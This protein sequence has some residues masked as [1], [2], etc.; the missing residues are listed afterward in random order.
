M[1]INSNGS[2]SG[3][4]ELQSSLWDFPMSQHHGRY[5]FAGRYNIPPNFISPLW[6]DLSLASDDPNPELY[7]NIRYGNGADSCEFIVEWDSLGVITPKGSGILND[8]SVFRVVL[9]K[10][11]QSIEYQ[12]DNIGIHGID[13]LG[14]IGMQQD[15]S[16]PSGT[17]P[18]YLF[19]NKNG[20][21]VETKIHNNFCIKFYAGAPLYVQPGWQLISPSVSRPGGINSTDVFG[22]K[23]CPFNYTP[24][25]G[26]YLLCDSILSP[27]SAF[28]LRFD[29]YGIA[30]IPGIPITDLT[31]N[32]N[33]GWNMI[34]GISKPISTS[35]IEKSIGLITSPFFK[36]E[37]TYNLSTTINPGVGYWVKANQAGTLYLQS[38]GSFEKSP[39][40]EY[41]GLHKFMFRNNAGLGQ[42]LYIGSDKT[43]KNSRLTIHELPPPAPYFN[44]RFK[45][46]GG[47]IATYPDKVETGA[48]NDYPISFYSESY[49]ITVEWELKNTGDIVSLIVDG[50][51]IMLNQVGTTEIRNPI[52]KI[53]LRLTAPSLMEIPKEFSLQQNYPNPFNPSTEIRYEVPISSRVSIKIFDI[54]GRELTALVDQFESPGVR[55]VIWNAENNPSGIYFVK[56]NANTYS[57][58]KKLMLIR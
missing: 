46:T 26:Y 2:F 20:Q 42:T 55:T 53:N 29:K 43:I 11:D 13:T 18:G 34:G 52:S 3:S 6:T 16:N 35:T 58:I 31:I 39:E 10:C 38:F 44:A 28:W 36:Y 24:V 21:P 47:M 50:K 1:D 17:E 54:L 12:Y 37:G 19:I 25:S 7:G 14:L 8:F 48:V 27:G 9:N 22:S 56:M 49:P 32:L 30:S 40:P 57:D 15:S 51:T 33:S 41:S 5:D 45:A 4:P 23:V